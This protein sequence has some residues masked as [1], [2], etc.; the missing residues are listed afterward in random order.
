MMLD[1]GK[2]KTAFP[3]ERCPEY[4]KN[5]SELMKCVVR[6]HIRNNITK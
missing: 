5:V 6:N 1:G 4:T 3:N 2:F